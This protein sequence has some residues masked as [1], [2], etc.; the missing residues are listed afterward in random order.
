MRRHFTKA[1]IAL[2]AFAGLATTTWADDKMMGKEKPLYTRLGGKKA[3][4][5]V[6][7][8]S[9]GRCAGDSRINGFF[10]QT[11]ADPKRH[12]KLKKKLVEQTCQASGRASKVWCTGH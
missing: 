8:E 3:I 1:M 10:K 7:D 6:V 4:T 12:A 2:V 5:A 11:A 9:V